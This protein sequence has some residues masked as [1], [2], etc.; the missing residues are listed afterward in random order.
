MTSSFIQLYLSSIREPVA[1]YTPSFGLMLGTW[2]QVL[3]FAAWTQ[4]ID[5][6]CSVS[7]NQGLCLK[8]P[9]ISGIVKLLILIADDCRI[10]YVFVC[11]CFVNVISWNLNMNCRRLGISEGSFGTDQGQN[12]RQEAMRTEH[13]PSGVVAILVFERR[14]IL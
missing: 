7:Y 5:V 4:W 6:D 9:W 8:L 11:V 3:L 14:R 12:V 1:R 2:F 10:L 13:L